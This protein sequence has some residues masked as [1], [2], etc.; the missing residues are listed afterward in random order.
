[1]PLIF[2][3]SPHLHISARKRDTWAMPRLGGR[4]GV[5]AHIR[6]MGTSWTTPEIFLAVAFFPLALAVALRLLPMLRPPKHRPVAFAALGIF[7]FL[8]STLSA[9]ALRSPLESGVFHHSSRYFGELHAEVAHQLFW[10]WF[11]VLTMY[12][13]GVFIAG[14][15]LAGIGLCFRQSSGQ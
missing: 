3:A 8:F 4:I 9:Y 11:L 1:M 15:G 2:L 5:R 10:Y 6:H 14:F 13:I 7:I 12:G